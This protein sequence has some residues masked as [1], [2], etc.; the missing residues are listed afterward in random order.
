MNVI[1]GRRVI[2][3]SPPFRKYL[4]Y[5]AILSVMLWFSPLTGSVA[6]SLTVPVLL[7]R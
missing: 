7:L 6:I 4:V 3:T 2:P 5:E 1:E